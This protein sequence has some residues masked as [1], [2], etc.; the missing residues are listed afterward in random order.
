MRRPP[1][2]STESIFGHGAIQFIVGMGVVMSLISI[3]VGYFSWQAGWESWQTLLFT[4]LILSQLALA[5]SVRSEENSLFKIGLFSNKSMVW[6]IL[7][8]VL[9][10]LAVIYVPFFQRIFDTQA[11]T[12]R[13]LLIAVGFATLAWLVVEIQKAVTRNRRSS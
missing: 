3:A 7:G 10:Q 12:L 4:T 9:L 2:S 13:E 1:Y 5:L 11:L 6:A 8:T